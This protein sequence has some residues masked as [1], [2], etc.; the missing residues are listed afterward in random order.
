MATLGNQR[1]IE[2]VITNLID[3][4]LRA[5]P[6]HGAILVSVHADGVVAVTDH[7]VGV[8]AADREMIFEPFWRKSDATPGTGL[9]LS[10]AR[11]IM[12]AHGGRIWV[13]DTAGG[14]AT[15]NL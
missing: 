15:F 5:E 3:N 10:I 1:A 13:E 6:K 12:D 11:E 9:G 14:G 2:C 7:G 8:S 4:A